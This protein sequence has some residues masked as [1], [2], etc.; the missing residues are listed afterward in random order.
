MPE[1]AYQQGMALQWITQEGGFPAKRMVEFHH[2][3]TD[4]TAVVTFGQKQ[5]TVR[6]A[7]LSK[8]EPPS[9]PWWLPAPFVV[10]P[11]PT[12]ASESQL[13]ERL[14]DARAALSQAHQHV[15]DIQQRLEDAK[16]VAL[17]AAK[18]LNTA[19]AAL[20]VYDL[21]QK[22]NQHALETAL[23]T[24]NAIP[25]LK[26][27]V[28]RHYLTDQTTRAETA[29]AKFDA[30]LAACNS[31]LTEALETVRS[32]ANE[33]ISLLVQQDVECLRRLETQAAISRA[34]LLAVASHWFAGAGSGPIKLPPAT[35]QY[36]EL[37]PAFNDVPEVRRGGPEGRVRPY[38]EI[39]D[40]LV[41]GDIEADF[42]LEKD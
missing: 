3:V 18:E 32:R 6:T 23:R 38:R 10:K 27:G 24:G 7:E 28:D 17:R 33:V 11:P 25:P 42:R 37:Q 2:S 34:Q 15:I 1:P 12:P 30:E 35:S 31:S 21:H 26:N 13:A 19:L 29:K 5:Y 14:A 4:D 22:A 41:Q 8:P 9:H 20:N 40:R 36:L 16:A 39:F